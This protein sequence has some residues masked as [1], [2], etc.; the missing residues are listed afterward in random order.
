MGSTTTVPKTMGATT[1]NPKTMG[2]TTTNPTIN[3]TMGAMTT[4]TMGYATTIPTINPTMGSTTTVPTINPT[5]A[6]TTTVPMTT[7]TMGFTTTAPM[8]TAKQDP[9]T[10]PPI[11]IASNSDLFVYRDA[12]G[13]A[14]VQIS[15][16]PLVPLNPSISA[17]TIAYIDLNN[18][19]TT[20][21]IS[22]IVIPPAG[23]NQGTSYVFN[24]DGTMI[25]SSTFPK[26]SYNPIWNNYLA[27]H[28]NL[29]PG[30]T[31]SPK[32]GRFV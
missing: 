20:N 21:T 31:T 24:T 25:S 29:L 23:T 3:P 17:D 8:T 28:P 22:V 18:S 7:P 30:P 10:Q 16:Y 1:T 4:P 27:V 14:Y 6:A 5:M 26:K 11:L 12:Q 13:Y 19:T 9:T 2:A 32:I 15:G